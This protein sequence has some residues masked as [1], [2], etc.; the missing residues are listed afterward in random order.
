MKD[1]DF[2]VNFEAKVKNETKQ[3][4]WNNIN[5]GVVFYAVV[6]AADIYVPEGGNQTIQQAVRNVWNPYPKYGKA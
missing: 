3:I 4:V 2:S 5:G 1:D 6:S